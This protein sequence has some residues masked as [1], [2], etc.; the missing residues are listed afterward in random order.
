MKKLETLRKSEQGFT[1]VELAIVMLIIGLLIGG[2][3]KGAELIGNAEIAA[4]VAQSKNVEAGTSGFRD[5]YGDFPGDMAAA[6][7]RITGAANAAGAGA[8][9]NSRLDANA[10]G[11]AVTAGTENDEFWNHLALAGFYSGDFAGL[12]M[13]APIDNLF[14]GVAYYAGGAAIGG[15][16][17]ANYAN[18]H[19]IT[20]TATATGA[21]NNASLRPD[22]AG[23][24]DRKLDDGDPTTGDVRG[25]GGGACGAAGLYDEDGNALTCGLLVRFQS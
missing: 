15:G 4:T 1:L 20:Y 2:V 23:R 24:M 22:Q 16:L 19:Y 8:R 18:G 25:A 10:V 3:L 11:A 14:L 5:K 9:G 12:A 17:G 7:A 13:N 21:A 6:A